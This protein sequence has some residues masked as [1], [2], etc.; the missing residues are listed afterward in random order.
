MPRSAAKAVQ[1]PVDA[2]WLPCA[3]RVHTMRTRCSLLLIIPPCVRG[4]E[5]IRAGVSQRFTEIRGLRTSSSFTEIESSRNVAQ[6]L[7][8]D[9]G[10]FSA[11]VLK[12]HILL[13]EIV[14]ANTPPGFFGLPLNIAKFGQNHDLT[15]CMVHFT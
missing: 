7:Q 5:S 3:H 9:F 4:V 6:I 14:L 10:T 12:F 1:R 8:I 13:P 15:V 11:D 2:V